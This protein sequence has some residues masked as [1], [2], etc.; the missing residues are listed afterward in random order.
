MTK[1]AKEA[2]LEQLNKIKKVVSKVLET[3]EVIHSACR[4]CLTVH[5][6]ITRKVQTNKYGH[7][8]TVL[9]SVL[10]TKT[11]EHGPKFPQ[12]DVVGKIETRGNKYH[13]YDTL[14]FFVCPKCQTMIFNNVEK[15]WEDIK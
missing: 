1:E 4:A 2:E 15:F 7:D 14:S 11:E 3:K 13:C 10:E 8:D 5:K 12:Y 9:E 6:T